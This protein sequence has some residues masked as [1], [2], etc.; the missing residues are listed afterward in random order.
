[1][2]KTTKVFAT[3]LAAMTVGTGFAGCFGTGGE[4][5]SDPA[6][7]SEETQKFLDTYGD[8]S[9]KKLEIT[10]ID[11]GLGTE[12]LKD[13]ARMFNKGTGSEIS[14]KADEQLNERL[15]SVVS[16]D[17][18]SDI[19]FSFSAEL[20]WIEW[21]LSE[22]IV[23]LT[24][25]NDSLA[26]RNEQ[27][28]KFG[29]YEDVRYIMPYVYS[30]T[31]FVYNKEYIAEIPSYGEF[32]Q[33]TFPTTWQGLLDLCYSINNNWKEVTLGQQVVPMSWGASVDD[34]NYIFKGLWA[35]VDYEGFNNYF[36]QP[37]LASVAN[38]EN[39][40]LL[41]NDSTVKVLDSIATLLNPQPNANGKYYPTNSFSDSLGHSNRD[42][43]QKFLNGLSVFCISGAWF[44]NEMREQIEDE[45][46]DFYSFASAPIINEGGKSTVFINAPSEYFMVT[47][48]GKNHNQELAKAFLTYMASEDATRLFHAS[49]GVPCSLIYKTPSDSLS[50]FAKG[51]ASVT[52]NSVHAIAGS[53]QL[54]SLAG[55]IHFQTSALFQ[56]LATT[57]ASTAHSTSLIEGIYAVQKADWEMRFEAFKN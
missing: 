13:A 52:D 11:K 56:S 24:D 5:G 8:W 40:S 34:M 17:N 20:Q 9:G 50:E 53:D 57:A 51:V 10:M 42:A 25:I 54:P 45:E 16:T 29:V 41:V 21:A 6:L 49:T 38:D 27:Y 46:L 22:A 47:A 39:K 18:C 48:K 30:P 44:E 7:T 55:A 12:W 15:A 14:V 35:Q 4:S 33:G 31:G 23:P 19:Y 32:T 2:K 1:M 43:Q 36:N 26:Y 37:Y 28:A 3:M